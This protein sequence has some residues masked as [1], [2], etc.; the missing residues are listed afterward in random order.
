MILIMIRQINNGTPKDIVFPT[1][2]FGKTETTDLFVFRFLSMG[3]YIY[4]WM[5]VVGNFM[6]VCQRILKILMIITL[7]PCLFH[8]FLQI[9]IPDGANSDEYSKDEDKKERMNGETF[10]RESITASKQSNKEGMCEC[11]WTRRCFFGTRDCFC[12]FVLLWMGCTL[13]RCQWF[14]GCIV[15]IFKSNT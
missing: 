10:E 1:Q 3:C 8:P 9:L 15:T 5:G 6:F 13:D 2:F 4:S 11:W 14:C 7:I 12:V